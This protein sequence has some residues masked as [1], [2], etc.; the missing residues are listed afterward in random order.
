MDNFTQN[1]QAPGPE[2]TPERPTAPQDESQPSAE[3]KPDSY[4]NE[5]VQHAID[6]TKQYFKKGEE[7]YKNSPEL[8][9]ATYQGK[10]LPAFWTVASIFSLVVN[11]ILIA[12]LIS[13]GHHF[14][15]LK[16]LVSTGLIKGLSDNLALMDKAHIV[17]TIPVNTTVQLQ[18]NLPVVFDLPVKQD[19]QVT[20]TQDTNID[21]AT[22]I[23]GVL[24]P[25]NVTLPAGTPLQLKLDTTVPVSQ[26]VPVDITVPVTMQV[27]IDLAISQTDLHQSIVGIQGAIAPYQV[28]LDQNFKSANDIAICKHWWSG[29]LCGIFF[30]EK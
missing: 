3:V 9:K 5:R 23:N 27:P 2:P 19:T 15:E 21:T 20:L 18:D 6:Q 13:F 10:F 17:T 4:L 28:L 12:V 24:V 16:T 25:M 8:Q 7:Y 22:N 26:S 30:G 11:I 14:F 29:W 1:P